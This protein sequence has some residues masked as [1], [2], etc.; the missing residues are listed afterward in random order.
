MNYRIIFYTLGWVMN[1][2]SACMLVPLICSVA[3]NDGHYM[4]Y[5]MCAILC[6]A[7]GVP[8]TWKSP[9]DKNM[10][11]REGL[12]SVALCW[13]AISIF[14]SF[15]FLITGAIP[16]FI[17]ALFETV[18]GFTTTGATILGD[19]EA[20]PKSLL[21]WRSF[22]HWI[23][24]MGVLVFLM[25]LLPL[26]GGK[27]MHLL[28][29][30]S[31]GPAVN[32]LVPKV[33]TNAKILYGIYTGLTALQFVLLLIG[34]MP[35][36]DAL[37]TAFGTAGTGGFGVRNDGMAGY[38]LYIQNVTSVFM[39]IFGIDFTVYYLLLMRRVK[40]SFRSEEVRTYL[41]IILVA[42]VLIGINCWGRYE[43]IGE[44][45]THSLFQVSSIITTTGFAS[46]DFNLWPQFSTTILVLLMFI[47]ACA[48]STG[49]GM[50]VSRILILIKTFLKEIHDTIRPN[51]VRKIKFS[52]RNVEADVIKAVSGYF[53]AFVA[54][55]VCSMLLISL[56][57]FDFTTNFTAV[58]ATINNIGPGLG[59]VGPMSNFS[60]YNWFS[61][62][63]FIFDM[64]V[65]RL[66][67][68]P[69]LVL[70]SRRTWRK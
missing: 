7:V 42:T 68:F 34:K 14:G 19:V 15:P 64:L 20:L 17:D 12:V 27:N 37:A 4:A 26:C 25:A 54:I 40:D 47:G 32:K 30:E 60:S 22:T 41:G 58:A 9:R 65:G 59:G 63:V 16:N 6:L 46:V 39:I 11:A 33:G 5:V 23:G 56:D 24:G 18:S 28:R 55:Y 31:T 38:S 50:K 10:Y 2:E 45:I 49:G 29:A 43:S 61:K 3:L 8:L 67:V 66:E 53:A 1:I 70:L 48:G 36:F 13:I 52:G 44:N 35:V 62:L 57:K 51:S 69:M 21:L